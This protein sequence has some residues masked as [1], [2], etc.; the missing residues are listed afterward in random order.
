M[1]LGLADAKTLPPVPTAGGPEF[2]WRSTGMVGASAWSVGASSSTQKIHPSGG[3]GQRGSGAQ[4]T[5][6]THPA[7]GCGQHWGGLNLFVIGAPSC[8][9]F[10]LER[11]SDRSLGGPVCPISWRPTN[12]AEALASPASTGSCVFP[13]QAA[14][15]TS[16]RSF[17]SA[18]CHIVM[19]LGPWPS[20]DTRTDPAAASP[21]PPHPPRHP[22]A[23]GGGPARSSCDDPYSPSGVISIRPDR[24][25]TCQTSPR[26][27]STTLASVI[28]RAATRPPSTPGRSVRRPGSPAHAAPDRS[29]RPQTPARAPYR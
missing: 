5:G 7:G 2:G 4:P 25:S 11:Y 24:S 13:C 19:I 1:K 6:G 20:V 15:S 10:H 22:A 8:E 14:L 18:T 21:D 28:V 16:L 27:T 9:R 12:S 26:T 29:T 3:A 23:A 17:V